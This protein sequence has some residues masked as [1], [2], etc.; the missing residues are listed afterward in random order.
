MKIAI[1]T[2]DYPPIEGGIASVSLH[3]SRELAALGHDVTVVAPWFPGMEEFDAKEPVTVIRFPGYNLG[4]FRFLPMLLKSRSPILSSEL[5]LGINIAYGGIMAWLLGA[6]YGTFAYAYEFLKFQRIPI[7]GALLR[8]VYS[9]S[10]KVIAISQFT[11]EQLTTFGVSPLQIET[12]LPGAPKVRS[13]D[14]TV[15][16]ELHDRLGLHKGPILLAVGRLIARKRHH[17][18]ID[19]MPAILREHPAAQLVIVG[20]G[21]L[22][23][24]L[25]SQTETLALERSVRMPGYLSDDDV[26]ALYSMCDIFTLPTGEDSGGHVEGFGLVFAEANAYGKPVVAGRSGGVTDAVVDDETGILV[27][28]GD[29]TECA[30]AIISLLDDPERAEIMGEAGRQRVESELSWSVFTRRLIDVMESHD[31]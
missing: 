28:P 31:V 14:D 1:P 13:I 10:T 3:V 20:R 9:R 6:R 4:W 22:E 17:T 7:V 29:V 18:L 21:P 25:K 12:V 24:E 8:R 2:A 5:T 16:R 23:A 26:A 27:T 19:S 15:K 11:A 30:N